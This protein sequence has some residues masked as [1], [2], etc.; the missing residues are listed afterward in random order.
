MSEEKPAPDLFDLKFLPAWVKE[1]PNENRYADFAGEDNV[2]PGSRDRR[3]RD[4]GGGDQRERRPR[5]PRG[6]PERGRD[7]RD[8]RDRNRRPAGP[9]PTEE[10]RPEAM[11]SA[12][13][14]VVE[15]R[16]LPDRRVLENVLA[17]IKAGHL[18]YSV[19][20][21]ARMF[22]DK[23][24][25]YDVHLKAES[26]TLF[27][28][29]ENGPVASDRR[30][31]E[32]GAFLDQRENFYKTEV[33]QS[34]P[35]KGNFTSVA[36]CRLSGTLLGP[37]NHHA[38]QPQLR[39][40]YEQRFSRRMSFQ[41]YQRQIEIVTDPAMVERWKEEARSVTTYTTLQEDPPVIFQS[42]A[43]TERHF[44]Q[45]YL[46]GLIKDQAELSLDGVVSRQLPDRSLGRVIEEAWA[47]DFRSP[48]KMMQEM[49]GSFRQSALHIFRHRKGM[50][51]V[52]PV[53]PRPFAGQ[54]SALSAAVAAILGALKEKPGINRKQLLDA[55]PD[56]GA[57][58]PEA[59][60][61]RKLALASNLHWLISEGYVIEF[62][63]GALDLPRSKPPAPAAA[64]VDSANG[65]GKVAPVQPKESPA[66][67]PEGGS[68]GPGTETPEI[69]E[70]ENAAPME[71]AMPIEDATPLETVA[72]ESVSPEA[73]EKSEGKN[74][75]LSEASRKDAESPAAD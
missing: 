6:G 27:Q 65:Q 33:T 36:R 41:D 73:E 46:P 50:L 8:A 40:L 31:L 51:F 9:R 68:D 35:I 43:E 57:T 54:T 74:P 3:D 60:E 67:S 28:L 38:Y 66:S 29:G 11:P 69:S 55:L 62:N 53:R 15:V 45:T 42:A 14:P 52:S 64:P 30:V 32:N 70:G 24:E 5:P 39:S 49:I 23:P 16:F 2:A 71:Q 20:S 17:Q 61:K 75:P 22:L 7:G 26:A 44:R 59:A 63:D 19:F 72:A 10:R 47:Q 4:R 1:S 58:E 21:L 56:D 18:A 25:R 37:T 13:L 48:T 12:P 34:E